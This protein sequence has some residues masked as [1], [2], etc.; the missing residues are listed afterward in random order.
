V[1]TVDEGGVIMP[2]IRYAELY[3]GA[4][5]LIGRIP[6]EV[7]DEKLRDEALKTEFNHKHLDW[8][9]ALESWGTT[10]APEK[11]KIVNDMLRWILWR[12]GWL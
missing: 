5:K 12:D 8:L 9:E 2:E 3:D 4:G 6:Y 7:S 10:S 11:W 1:S